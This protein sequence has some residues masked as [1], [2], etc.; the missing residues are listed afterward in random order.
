MA[1]PGNVIKPSVP[2]RTSSEVQQEREA[3]AKAKVD[4]E[5]AKQQGILR[6]AEF[7][8]TDM[9]NE[10]TVNVTPHPPFTPNP[11]PPPCNKKKSKLVPVTESSG[12]EIHDD[13]PDFNKTPLMPVISEGSITEDELA[14]EDES[15]TESDV[16]VPPV[17]KKKIR[18]T[19]TAGMSAK[20][21]EKKKQ[22][23]GDEKEVDTSDEEEMPKP[24]KVK[25]KVHDEINFVTKKNG[26]RQQRK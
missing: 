6:A 18:A 16:L 19:Q 9:A 10:D 23:D 15:S 25:A 2:C 26:D 14:I 3:R 13:D 7:E 1:H 21:V 22:V 24:K 20:V 4:C 17:K 8:H 5:A 12:V 11:W